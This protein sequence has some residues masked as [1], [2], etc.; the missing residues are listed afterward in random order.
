MYYA[1]VERVPPFWLRWL[2]HNPRFATPTLLSHQDPVLL[3]RV[4]ARGIERKWAYVTESLPEGED[5]VIGAEGDFRGRTRDVIRSVLRPFLL[6]RTLIDA[7]TNCAVGSTTLHVPV[8][9]QLTARAATLAEVFHDAIRAL[10]PPLV[11]TG[12]GCGLL[13]TVVIDQEY[14]RDFFRAASVSSRNLQ[15]P[16]NL[17][18]AVKIIGE[19]VATMYASPAWCLALLIGDLRRAKRS[20]RSGRGG[21]RARADGPADELANQ[22]L[23]LVQ[24]SYNVV[25]S[26]MSSSNSETAFTRSPGRRGGSELNSTG[27]RTPMCSRTAPTATTTTRALGVA[28]MKGAERTATLR[29]WRRLRRRNVKE[30]LAAAHPIPG[31]RSRSDCS[32][33]ISDFIRFDSA[34]TSMNLISNLRGRVYQT[35]S[36]SVIS[37]KSQSA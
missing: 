27:W 8:D 2:A 18:R 32:S 29:V 5:A 17:L 12:R 35:L 6:N 30:W 36:P 22:G 13:N 20:G 25:A 26:R 10:N 24:L 15:R 33:H 28:M 1:P 11:Q 34:N 19:C 7:L 23:E 4:Y 3:Q 16:H 21:E 14:T 37:A 9:E 31:G